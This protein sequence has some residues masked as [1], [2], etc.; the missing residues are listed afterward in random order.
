MAEDIRTMDQVKGASFL[1][2]FEKP[3]C[4][5]LDSAYCSMGRMIGYKAC[6]KAG[7]AYYDAVTLL[8]LVP[9]SG[10][11]KEDV[12]RVE[13]ALRDREYTKEELL[14]NAEL[15]NIIAVFNQAIS[16]ALSKGNCLIHDRTVKEWVLSKGY[17]CVNVFTTANNDD[18]KVERALSS[19]LYQHLT[20]RKVV[21]E[22]IA[23]ENHIRSNYHKL[24]S[25][26]PWGEA[27][28]YDL[29][30][31]SDVLGREYCATVLAHIMCA[32]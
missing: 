6:Q 9:E 11:T 5:V 32:D 31:N 4:V 8:E 29:I 2:E 16:I 24:Q 20:D 3:N 13:S 21:L 10:I 7:Y 22:K 19:P 15:Q 27:E 30:L 1:V 26:T 25:D 14:A 12:D 18:Y 28:T 17:S 23:E